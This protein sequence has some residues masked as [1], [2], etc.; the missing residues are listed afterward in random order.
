MP[1]GPPPTPRGLR[2]SRRS[3]AEE[4]GSGEPG[5]AAEEPGA[6]SVRVTVDLT[7]AEYQAL[8]VWLARAS[9]QLD[10][11]VAAMTVARGI[12]AMIQAAATDNAVGDAVLGVMGREGRGSSRDGKAL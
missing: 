9:L 3:R 7:P 6:A 4:P 11:P 1:Y 12:R 8:N 2:S 5:A 10:Q